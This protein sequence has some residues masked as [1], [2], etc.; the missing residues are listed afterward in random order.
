MTL[1][2]VEEPQIMPVFYKL[3]GMKPTLNHSSIS[4][5]EAIRSEM[6]RVIRIPS[7]P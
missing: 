6:K 3:Y 4:D 5:L 2:Y 7:A 1:G